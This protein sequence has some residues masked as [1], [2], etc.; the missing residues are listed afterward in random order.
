MQSQ[1][2]HFLFIT[3]RIRFALR[4]V[5]S[6]LIAASRLISFPAGTKTFQFPAFLSIARLSEEKEVQ[7][8]NLWF[9]GCLHLARAYRCL[10]RPS[11]AH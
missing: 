7:L 4:R 3:E 11:S 5:R 10:P 2:P 1:T 8:R 6:L 9:K